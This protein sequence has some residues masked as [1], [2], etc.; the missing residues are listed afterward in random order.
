[1]KLGFKVAIGVGVVAVGAGVLFGT[2]FTRG[3][4]KN[5]WGVGTRGAGGQSPVGHTLGAPDNGRALLPDVKNRPVLNGDLPIEGVR[6]Y[7]KRAIDGMEN[8]RRGDPD[9]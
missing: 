6:Q 1:M 8:I 7:V 4:V 3:L 2:P 9:R 5:Y